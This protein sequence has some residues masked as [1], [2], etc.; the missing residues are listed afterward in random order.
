MAD[1]AIAEVA[2]L[3]ELLVVLEYGHIM[4]LVFLVLGEGRVRR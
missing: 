3:V 4:G 1:K 2:K